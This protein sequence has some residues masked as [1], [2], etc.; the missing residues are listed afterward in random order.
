MN[1]ISSFD[2]RSRALEVNQTRTLSI[3]VIL[4]LVMNSPRLVLLGMEVNRIR[5]FV[6][7]MV[8]IQTARASFSALHIYALVS[9]HRPLETN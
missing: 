6:W 4:F 8:S 5:S 1:L 9:T 2:P 3:A 7:C